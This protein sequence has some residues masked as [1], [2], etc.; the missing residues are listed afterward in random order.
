MLVAMN[1]LF[2]FLSLFLTASVGTAFELNVRDSGARGDGAT[3]DTAA[4][5][6]ALDSAGDAGGGIVH[7]PSGHYRI[8]GHLVIPGGVTLQGTYRVPPTNRSD[9]PHGHPRIHGSVLLAYAGRGSQD[10]PPFIRLGGSASVLAGVVIVYPEWQQ[11]DV[12]PIPYPPCILGETYDNM[13]VLDCLLVN[14]YEGIRFVGA[15]RNFVR[16]VYGYPSWRGLYV[17][18]CYDIGRVENCHFWPFGVHYHQDDPYCKWINTQGVAFEFARTDWHY[19][20]NTFCFGYGVGYKFSASSAGSCNGNFLGIGADSCRRPVLVEQ[21][22]LQGLLI[23]NGEFVGRWGSEDSVCIEIAPAVEGKVSLANCAFWGPIDRCV[24][25]RSRTGNFT[26]VGCNFV[27]WDNA[28]KGSPAI[29]LDAGSAILQGNTFGQ[30]GTHVLVAD[31]VR[32]ALI[33]GNQA[34]DGLVVDNHAGARTQ[35]LANESRDDRWPPNSLLHYQIDIG[36]PGD[37]RFLVG[38]HNNERAHGVPSWRW[39]SGASEF[40]LPVQPGKAYTL[41]LE[42]E[43]PALAR[44][45]DG[46]LYL[47]D[48]RIAA[49][50]E[51]VTAAV[52]V[53][54]IPAARRDTA[55]VQ[56]R[57]HTWRPAEHHPGS[58]DTRELGIQATR[59]VMRADKAPKRVFGA[60]KGQWLEADGPQPK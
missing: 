16:N 41:T 59:L 23:T 42:A 31:A 12:P 1:N 33:I 6:R 53:A 47:D 57:A 38:W 15:G 13:G 30:P 11:S 44:G 28:A 9:G 17:D 25:H 49:W 3:D 26:A 20:L 52:V 10:G 39:S 21:A 56:V 35:L 58:M 8:A 34:A 22:Q 55:V 7:V 18:Q 46:G 45:A 29:Q 40:R 37:G 43:I 19:V 14:P 36:E 48:K 51:N 2:P 27:H 32:S 24:W 5:Q 60:N 54:R 50:P 4:V